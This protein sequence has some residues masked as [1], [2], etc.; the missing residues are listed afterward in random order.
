MRTVHLVA[1][2]ALVA[3]TS[4]CADNS[5]SPTVEDGGCAG[6]KCD[7]V[8][9]EDFACKDMQN[10]S[11]RP[12]A[13]VLT[14]LNDPFADMLK[15]GEPGCPSTRAEMMERFRNT[16]TEG[17]EGTADGLRT[18]VVTET[19]QLAPESTNSFRLVTTRQCADRERHE[20]VFSVFGANESRLPDSVEI[21]ALD[22]DAG[23]FNYYTVEGGEVAFHG[24]STDI[25]KGDAGRCAAC[26]TGGGLVMK[27]LRSPWIHWESPASTP[28]A[29]AILDAH[30]DDLGSRFTGSSMESVTK[31][32]NREWNETRINTMLQPEGDFTPA[33]LLQP[34]FCGS[35]FNLD[36]AATSTS[37]ISRL[38]ENLFGH[39]LLTGDSCEGT[40]S[41]ES[42]GVSIDQETYDAA[43]E[44]AGG[45]VQGTSANDTIFALAF[46]EPA[47]GDINYLSQLRTMGVIDRD[48]TR[49]VLSIDFT[50][51]VESEERCELLAFAPSWDQLA[52][53]TTD[54]GEPEPPSGGD[55]DG[56]SDTDTDSGS[57]TGDG[58]GDTEPA[59]RVTAAQLKAGFIANLQDAGVQADGEGAASQLLAALQNEEDESAHAERFRSFIETCNGRDK[60]ELID[61]VLIAV[62]AALSV[63]RSHH[64]ME[65][66]ATAQQYTNLPDNPRAHLDPATCELVE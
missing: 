50:R 54:D 52:A 34:L 28:G 35:E 22:R 31:A 64:V 7:D 66:P 56:G 41:G 2:T 5:S 26:H 46:V 43:L 20:L 4:A 45:R 21:M 3:T 8:E 12:S 27:E 37:R 63:A 1:L 10:L 59:A 40:H 9:P 14:E 23:E 36:T 17:C 42:R 62:N 61:D 6:G 47:V 60:R 58:D 30:A 51:P 44:A 65:F 29:A 24:S 49:D 11:R 15:L 48:L 25:L 57:D 16:D 13:N 55:T 38:P 18:A 39:C 53:L 33:D 32:G 19:G